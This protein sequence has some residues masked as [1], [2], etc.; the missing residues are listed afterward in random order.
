MK[1]KIT[2]CK[3]CGRLLDPSVLEWKEKP[4]K[5][6]PNCPKCNGKMEISGTVW[7]SWKCVE[8]GH[9]SGLEYCPECRYP[10][11]LTDPRY[12]TGL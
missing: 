11:D 5:E 10:K 12:L 9:G 7:L 4:E 1:E 8:C 6:L 3:T 2:T